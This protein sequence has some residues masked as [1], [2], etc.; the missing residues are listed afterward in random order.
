MVRLGS[1]LILTMQILNSSRRGLSHGGSRVLATPAVPKRAES[2]RRL[3]VLLL[4]GSAAAVVGAFYNWEWLV[5]LGLVPLLLSA[6]PC[7]AICAL[8]LCMTHADRSACGKAAA[9]RQP[10]PG[11][12]TIGEQNRGSVSNGYRG[13]LP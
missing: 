4:T 6:L 2:G 10:A 13:D 11:V 7:L 12:E 5:A 3:P 8:G 1:R 9:L